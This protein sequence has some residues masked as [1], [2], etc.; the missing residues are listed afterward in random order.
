MIGWLLRLERGKV[1]RRE[2]DGHKS[3]LADDV[4]TIRAMLQAQND[5]SQ[6]HRE[7]VMAQLGS[8]NTKVAVIETRLRY[9]RTAS[10]G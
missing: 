8:L 5:R 3:T 9:G 7:S 2:M 1:G 10:T 6:E 4:K